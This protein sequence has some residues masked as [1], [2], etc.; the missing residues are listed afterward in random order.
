[1]IKEEKKETKTTDERIHRLETLLAFLLDEHYGV[2]FLLKQ[3]IQILEDMNLVEKL[4]ASVK[5]TQ[6]PKKTSPIAS[7][8]SLET[9]KK[10]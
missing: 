4:P 2:S 3:I 9:D 7:N 8:S 10:D 6:D 1:M 5:S